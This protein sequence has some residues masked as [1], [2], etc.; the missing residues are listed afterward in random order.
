MNDASLIRLFR[1]SI[2]EGLAL[3]GWLFPVVQR[4]QPTQQGIPTETTVFFQK[5]FDN[6]YGQPCLK[7]MYGVPTP[8][9]NTEV[10]TQ[11]METT[12][13]VSVLTLLSPSMN[14]DNQPTASDISNYVANILQRRDTVRKMLASNNVNVLR[15]SKVDNSYFEDDRHRNEAWPTFEV[16]LTHQTVTSN[17]VDN[18]ANVQLNIY[19]VLD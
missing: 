7:T 17:T 2:V 12:F 19:P 15:I 16:V 3:N 5:L 14:T 6:R 10:T 11:H 18:T 4:S 9:L 1:R 8:D 13:Q